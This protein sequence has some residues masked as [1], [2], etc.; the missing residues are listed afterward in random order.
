EQN[1]L[2]LTIDFADRSIAN[3][4]DYYP[5][6]I[7]ADSINLN[8]GLVFKTTP[9][10]KEVI[11]NGS[12]KGELHVTANKKDF[13]FSINLYE[14][15]PE[16]K[17]FHLSY[18]IGRA[19]YS[20]SREIRELLTPG[21]ETTIAFNNTRIVSKKIAKGSQLVAI[22]NG[23]KNP[24]AQI[25]YGSGKDVSTESIDDSKYPLVLK[26]SPASKLFL[27]IWQEHQ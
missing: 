2:N 21:V 7:I 6:P 1:P 27:P 14:L 17:Y 12:F 26:I 4:A 10:E 15:T 11:I 5:W 8:D 22:V 3:N 24:Y 19:S 23:N 25:N 18:Y 20:K 13:D 16:G 9:F